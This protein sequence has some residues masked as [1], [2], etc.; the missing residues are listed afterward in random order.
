MI[1][2]TNYNF[3]TLHRHPLTGCQWRGSHLSHNSIFNEQR[4]FTPENLLSFRLISLSQGTKNLRADLSLSTRP[5]RASFVAAVNLTFPHQLSTFSSK[6]FLR[7]FRRSS[8]K[9]RQHNSERSKPRKSFFRFFTHN[10]LSF[11]RNP[12][13]LSK[14]AIFRLCKFL[15]K[16]KSHFPSEEFTSRR[17]LKFG[18]RAENCGRLLRESP[19]C[20]RPTLQ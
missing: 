7:C 14:I 6:F 12:E 13:F 17:N 11:G 19:S 2:R 20:S 5:L 3:K 4:V 9:E 15:R 16:G 10:L 18:F 8:R 1:S